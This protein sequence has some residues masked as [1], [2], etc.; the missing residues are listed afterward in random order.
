WGR[1]GI[2]SG[3][4]VCMDVIVDSQPGGIGV[5][6]LI[7]RLDLLAASEVRQRFAEAI[8]AGSRRLVVDLADG[9]F[10]HSSGLA[11]LISG[12]KAARLASGDLRIARPNDQARLLL[13][14][15]R[16]DRV[17]RLYPTVE[18]ALAGY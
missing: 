17:L 7:G 11:A 14:L 10:I 6:R 5:V 12:L 3:G 1:A 8:A 4:E 13:E 15:T 2:M 16:L 18:D 9:S